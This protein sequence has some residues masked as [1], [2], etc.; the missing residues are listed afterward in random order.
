M[1]AC[2]QKKVPAV[3]DNVGGGGWRFGEMPVFFTG[4]G[5]ETWAHQAG[6]FLSFL[7][8]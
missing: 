7:F 8:V 3:L 6:T 2:F 1:I 5:V 4:I